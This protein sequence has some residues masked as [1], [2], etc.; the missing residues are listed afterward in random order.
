MVADIKSNL[1][2]Q[3]FH[4]EQ[5]S[6]SRGTAQGELQKGDFVFVGDRAQQL[7][8][9]SKTAQQLGPTRSS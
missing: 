1:K 9:V 3:K 2:D 8:N 5:D 7:Q 4:P 6:A